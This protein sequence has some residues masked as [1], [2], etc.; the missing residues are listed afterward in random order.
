MCNPGFACLGTDFYPDD[1]CQGS[2]GCCA[3]FCDIT[4]GNDDCMG[5]NI[6]GIE[7][8]GWW[9]PEPAPPGYEDVG[10]CAVPA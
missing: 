8:V 7:C 3:P 4:N 6:M 1:N 2:S 5:I 9:D 10:V